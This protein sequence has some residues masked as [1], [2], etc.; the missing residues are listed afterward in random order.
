MQLEEAEQAK[1]AADER[2]AIKLAERLAKMPP[3]Q[4]A[5]A[6]LFAAI[7]KNRSGAIERDEFFA[8]LLPRADDHNAITE[9]WTAL[10]AAS[11]ASGCDEAAFVRWAEGSPAQFEAAKQVVDRA[12]SARPSEAQQLARLNVS[13]R[14]AEVIQQGDPRAVGEAAAEVVVRAADGEQVVVGKL[15]AVERSSKL[16]VG[17][18]VVV[19]GGEDK[20]KCGKLI[21]DDGTSTPFK[22]EFEDG[23]KSSWLRKKDVKKDEWATLLARL[24]FETA[25]RPASDFAW[26]D[27][28]SVLASVVRDGK[29]LKAQL[30][31]KPSEF[32]P[33]PGSVW[34]VRTLSSDAGALRC[35]TLVVQE[36]DEHVCTADNGGKEHDRFTLH[37]LKLASLSHGTATLADGTQVVVVL[38]IPAAG[39]EV[40]QRLLVV[41][42]KDGTL[43]DAIVASCDLDPQQPAR[44]M[45]TLSDGSAPLP[46]DLGSFNHCRQLMAS[47]QTFLTA[48]ATYCEW[49]IVTT[50]YVEDGI[51]GT[52]LRTA[53]QLLAIDARSDAGVTREGFS[54]V[55]NIAAL[56]DAL[57]APSLQR[58]HGTLHTQPVL[59]C[60]APGTG[61]TWAAIRLTYAMAIKCKQVAAASAGTPLVPVRSTTLL[62]HPFHVSVM[63]L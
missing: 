45:L 31:L 50:E 62:L 24:T 47:T 15:A 3:E 32:S 53:D 58:A 48:A 12:A 8:F 56:C 16:K 60:A 63:S 40:G 52:K 10:A 61:K 17:D 11:P 55:Q 5:K 41:R 37:Q 35:A 7:D 6:E 44:H 23:K 54:D 46:F 1:T 39:R 49:L 33:R 14:G 28:Q 20:G 25:A 57:I 42:D 19:V 4:R 30:R 51:T 29:M 2:S 34:R 21:E 18:R 22:V 13:F 27:G 38:D 59:V 36:G 9:W 26:A 43:V